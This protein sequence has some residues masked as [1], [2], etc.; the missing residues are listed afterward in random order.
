[1][2]AS[3]AAAEPDSAPEE[4]PPP[5]FNISGVTGS[6]IFVNSSSSSSPIAV[7]ATVLVPGVGP[8][9]E[10]DWPPRRAWIIYEPGA[11]MIGERRQE[12]MQR[13]RYAFTER[14][15]RHM[16]KGGQTDRPR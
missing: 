13:L 4:G 10:M 14:G 12:G 15:E 5:A 1:M 11:R 9:D 2:Q 6:R 16:S 3:D 8:A 7:A